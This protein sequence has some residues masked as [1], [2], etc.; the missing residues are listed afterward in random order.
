MR[1]D[2]Q[3]VGSLARFLSFSGL[4]S[5]GLL[6]LFSFFFGFSRPVNLYR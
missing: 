1:N 3:L 2:E 5:Q 4:A 6:I